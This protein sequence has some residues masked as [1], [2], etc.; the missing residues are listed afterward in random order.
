MKRAGRQNPRGGPP[1]KAGGT[2]PQRA[3][4]GPPPPLIDGGRFIPH[5]TRRLS[6]DRVVAVVC[7][8]LMQISLVFSAYY[9]LCLGG[10]PCAFA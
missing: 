9:P 2:L 8:E 3:C 4:I 7:G 1:S 10:P 6:M 5:P